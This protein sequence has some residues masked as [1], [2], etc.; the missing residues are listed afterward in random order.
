MDLDDVLEDLL[1]G[2]RRA[3]RDRDRRHHRRGGRGGRPDVEDL[4]GDLPGHVRRWAPAAAVATG[5]GWFVLLGLVAVGVLLAVGGG[6][7]VAAAVALGVLAVFGLPVAAWGAFGLRRRARTEQQRSRRQHAQEQD[8][9]RLDG[10]PAAIRHDWAR[11]EQARALVGE[12]ADEGWVSRDA[13]GELDGTMARLRRA[14]EVEARTRDLGG[15]SSDRLAAQVADLADLLVALAD[16]AV[17]HQADV[18]AGS[19]APATLAQAR[20]RMVALR[21]ARREVDG[22]DGTRGST[23]TG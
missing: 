13:I 3:M 15:R 20:E 17:E 23:S 8:R 10:V 5:L 7:G 9:H 6:I 11:L 22:I 16:E 2:A 4:L 12:L 19:G 14:L 18:V 1:E 21:E